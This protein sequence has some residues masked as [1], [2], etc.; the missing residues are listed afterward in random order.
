MSVESDGNDGDVQDWAEVSGTFDVNGL[1]T[2]DMDDLENPSF[3][4]ILT[5][6]F[7][8]STST[9]IDAD[10]DGTADDLSAFGTIYDAI[11]VPDATGDEASLYGSDVGGTDFAYTGQEPELIFRSG[12]S[13]DLYAV[14]TLGDS[15]VYDTDGNS[16]SAS[17]FASDPT[18]GPTFGEINP[19]RLTG[20][21]ECTTDSPLYIS[22]FSVDPDEVTV[23]N[24][25]TAADPEAVALDE[26]TLAVYNGY[27]ERV[28]ETETAPGPTLL[29]PQGSH[30][31][32]VDIESGDPG[33]VVLSTNSS[34]TTG[35]TVGDATGTVVAGVVFDATGEVYEAQDGTR[36]EC[37]NGPD[38]DPCNSPE[39]AANFVA[40]L[41]AVFGG[42]TA[43]ED[44]GAVALGVA[45]GPNPIRGAA[46]VTYGVVAP[47]DVRVSVFDALGR[48]VAVLAEGARGPGVYQAA[49]DGSALPAGVYVVR[50]VVG[51]EA[52]MATVTVVR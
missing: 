51:P 40:A 3:T 14:N 28:T 22:T 17:D 18:S 23:T 39:G 32:S 36:G 30:P 34:L 27:S 47:A 24:S 2:V 6:D 9:D 10:D 33:A 7:T 16:V 52:R 31:Y 8:G 12:S 50:A 45:V 5:G 11:G 49:L 43:G 13:G 44:D 42:A 4:V 29:A 26:C 25:S 37:G 38:V 21:E 35:S 15:E 48:E 41:A 20:D 46:R 1:L 19:V